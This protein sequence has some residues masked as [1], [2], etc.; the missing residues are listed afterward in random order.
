[1][2]AIQLRHM[3][4]D[5]AEHVPFYRRHWKKAGV[6]L[7]RIYSSVPLEFLP[8]VTRDDLL[9]CPPED[10]LDRRYRGS[11][12]HSEL[13]S[14]PSGESFEFP[15]DKRTQT[16]RR[17]RFWQ[18]L[19]DIGH[20]PGERTM[21]ITD[22]ELPTGAALLRRLRVDTSLDDEA[23]FAIYS[24]F[25]PTLVCGPLSSLSRLAA[26]VAASS[27]SAW[28]PRL[29]VS[30]AEHLTDAKRA[31]LESTLGA[32]VA[33]FYSTP[34]Q[35]LIAYSTPGVAGYRSLTDEFVIESPQATPGKSG[36][37]RLIVT[38]LVPGA[39]PLIRFD[40]GDFVMRDLSAR[41]TTFAPV[42]ISAFSQREVVRVDR[43]IRPV[44]V[45]ARTVGALDGN[46]SGALGA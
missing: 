37:G 17:A 20:V 21:L 16:R 18:A 44:R 1:M 12:L 15:T 32:K 13:S 45:P 9:A 42:P 34:E 39:M 14:A 19:R 26:R 3:I 43:K 41:G 5:A 33:D 24:K 7:T 25:R 11:A 31:L 2:N 29:V 8:V 28:R 38:D 40:T 6:D 30:T 35:G 23:V 36:P 27:E 4:M 46:L 10:R 22:D